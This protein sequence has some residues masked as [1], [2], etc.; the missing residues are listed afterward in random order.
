MSINSAAI[1]VNV[2]DNFG[3]NDVRGRTNP[4]IGMTTDKGMITDF[5]P[6]T[7]SG[8]CIVGSG[9]SE[10]KSYQYTDRLYIDMAIA[11]GYNWPTNAGDIRYGSGAL[12]P[13]TFDSPHGPS[14]VFF[15]GANKI[16]F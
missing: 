15:V 11:S 12:H 6:G 8:V 9:N 4:V 13:I 16:L 3:M 2:V 1:L 14:G 10:N 7:G 5:V